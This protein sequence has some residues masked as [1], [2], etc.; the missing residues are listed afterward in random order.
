MHQVGNFYAYTS[1]DPRYSAIN[2][3][4]QRQVGGHFDYPR[5]IVLA[6]GREEARETTI[7]A[8]NGPIEYQENLLHYLKETRASGS[9]QDFPKPDF[10]VSLKKRN[11]YAFLVPVVRYANPA[12]SV[13]INT[14]EELQ[15][16]LERF[17][18]MPEYQHASIIRMFN[19]LHPR[20]QSTESPN[21]SL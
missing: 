19:T 14:V 17:L 2:I 13:L 8:S 1:N 6:D 3:L 11:G 15:Q 5:Y 4:C 16:H 12:Q 18:P 21:L 20:F 10:F 7:L 9:N